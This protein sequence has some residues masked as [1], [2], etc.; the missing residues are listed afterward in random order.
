MLK[1][2]DFIEVVGQRFWKHIHNKTDCPFADSTP[3]RISFLK[4]LVGKINKMIY[5]PSPPRTFV[6]SHKENLVVR[7]IPALTREDYCVYYYCI[8][9][10]EDEIAANRVKGTYGGWKLGGKIRKIENND[11]IVS[12][13][14]YSYN[15]FAWKRAWTDYQKRA[16]NLYA[17]SDHEYYFIF[18]IANFYDSIRLDRLE[19]LIREAVDKRKT[20]YVNLLFYFLSHWNKKYMF[21]EKQSAGLP[22]DEVGDCS[23]ILANYYLQEYD[24][25][26]YDICE[27]RKSKY[28]RYAD[29]QI[30]ASKNE[31]DAKEIMFLASKKLAMIGLNLNASKAKLFTSRQFFDYWSFDIFKL[32]ENPK[33]HKDIEKAYDAYRKK[34]RKRVDFKR[35]PILKRMINCNIAGLAPK[36]R[37]KVIANV[38]DE[39]FIMNAGGYYLGKIFDLLNK[40][41]R[42]RYIARLNRLSKKILFN[43]YHLR[44]MRL[45]R[46]KK[47]SED[48][49]KDVVASYDMV[50]QL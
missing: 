46:E 25:Y 7:F 22:Q 44:V 20:K 28:L 8:K 47:I 1:D 32:L 29:D 50:N 15:S 3:D 34:V 19:A 10:L 18:D 17:K 42:V 37:T 2:N 26:M 39:K 48:K 30:I 13:P 14:D 27:E 33:K 36:Y 12:M 43:Q 11:E 23:R 35:S 41:Q 24:K 40:R 9:S 21:Y 6:V 45:A 4:E 16:Y 38:L 5:A 49:I 31:K